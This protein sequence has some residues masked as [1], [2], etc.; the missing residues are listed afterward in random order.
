MEA[1]NFSPVKSDV[2]IYIEKEH[3]MFDSIICA[4]FHDLKI[5]QLLSKVNITKRCGITT[6]KVVYNL[7]TVPFL[8]ISTVCLFVR[9]QFEEAASKDV[10]Y[11]FLDNANYNWHQFILSL[12]G[13]IEGKLTTQT[14]RKKPQNIS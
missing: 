14:R 2:H 12:S 8:M 5:K 6:T 1:K 9:N 10:Y 11:R 4:V 7:F 13:I 3:S